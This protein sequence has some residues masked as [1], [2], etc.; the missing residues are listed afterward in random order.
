MQVHPVH[1]VPLDLV[2]VVELGLRRGHS[3]E[4]HVQLVDPAL[5]FL[6]LVVEQPKF[7][8]VPEWVLAWVIVTKFG[9]KCRFAPM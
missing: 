9:W 5:D 7:G 2:K 3:L 4:L 1:V 6:R 8:H